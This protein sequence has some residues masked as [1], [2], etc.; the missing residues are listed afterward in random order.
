[1]RIGH[2]RLAHAC[3]GG[4]RSL[5]VPG[6]LRRRSYSRAFTHYG[7][8]ALIGSDVCRLRCR[9]TV[10]RAWACR[11]PTLQRESAGGTNWGLLV[12]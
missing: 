10:L 11:A 3:F 7:K 5:A 6:R 9:R 2:D 12:N 4:L 8:Q 1:M